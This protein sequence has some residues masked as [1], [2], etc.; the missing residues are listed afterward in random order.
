[1]KNIEII[2]QQ[3]TVESSIKEQAIL[4]KGEVFTFFDSGQTRYVFTNKDKTKVIKILIEKNSKDFNLEEDEIYRN[5]S[6]EKRKELAETKLTMNGMIIE[7]EFCN[8]IKFDNRKLT[9][10]QMLFASSCRNEVGWNKEGEL[11][12]FDLDEYR[13][14]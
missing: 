13:K 4:Y 12:C 6:D 3:E 7:Q 5:A 14:Y 9:I 11:V 8:P 10:P 1:V 2:I